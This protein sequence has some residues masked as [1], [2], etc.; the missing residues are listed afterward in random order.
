MKWRGRIENYNK[1]SFRKDLISG[2]IVGIIA[3]PLGMAF[4]I[5]SGV[6]PEYGIYTTIIAGVLISIFGGSKFQIGA[7]QAHLY[8]YFYQL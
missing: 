7:Q 4:A 3:I 6:K 5:S 8:L 2:I 1:V